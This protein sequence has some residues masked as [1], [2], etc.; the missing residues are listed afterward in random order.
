MCDPWMT[1]FLYSNLIY[2][3]VVRCPLS[4]SLVH[5]VQM[6]PVAQ[7]Y[8]GLDDRPSFVMTPPVYR[9]RCWTSQLG[10]VDRFWVSSPGEVLLPVAEKMM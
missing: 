6:V 7:L 3:G 10:L 9:G 4:R 8:E 5:W 2:H 1:S